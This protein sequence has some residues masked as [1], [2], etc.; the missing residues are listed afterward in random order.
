MF[1]KQQSVGGK[2]AYLG[3]LLVL[4]LIT[5]ICLAPIWHMVVLSFS[6]K[7]AAAGGLVTFYPIGFTLTPYEY[8]LQDQRFFNSFLISIQRVL[9]GGALN[10]ILT[11]LAAYPLSKERS[12]FPARNKLM[13]I[14]VFTMMFNGGLIPWYMTVKMT[15]IMDTVWA[16]V[17]PTAVPVFNVILLMNFFRGIGKEVGEA[18]TMDGAGPFATLFRIYIPMST[19]AIATV[20]LFSIVHHWNSFFDGM[21]LINDQNRQPLQTYIR[22]LVISPLLSNMSSIDMEELMK[23]S[24]K[25]FS[26]A[27]IVVTMV[28]VLMVYPFLQKYFVTGI[29][30]GS[31]KE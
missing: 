8:I 19:A 24:E 9:L 18:A 26:A 28:P 20:T 6:D 22:S 25:T 27:K 14:F 7:S 5:V 16:L 29:S 10:F 30:L 2:L 1:T 4:I 12:E 13:W 17:L 15:G 11:V 3:L 23:L 31:V 21:V